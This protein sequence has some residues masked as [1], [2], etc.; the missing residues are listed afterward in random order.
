MGAVVYRS[1]WT[2]PWIAGT[3]ALRER[4]TSLWEL[5]R[6]SLIHEPFTRLRPQ[7]L[8]DDALLP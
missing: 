5:I 1:G 8:P 6:R 2:Q 4:K 3:L 7:M